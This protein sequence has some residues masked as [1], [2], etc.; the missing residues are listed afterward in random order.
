MQQMPYLTKCVLTYTDHT[1]QRD[2][3]IPGQSWEL[4][5]V[6]AEVALDDHFED[7]E[8]Y[9]SALAVAQGSVET[10]DSKFTEAKLDIQL[11]GIH[12]RQREYFPP[13]KRLR[14][15]PLQSN[16]YDWFG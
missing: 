14:P 10:P 3:V 6:N 8:M 11:M 1:L 15:P 13:G 7:N 2:V 16:Y 5:E 9:N 12:G 4:G